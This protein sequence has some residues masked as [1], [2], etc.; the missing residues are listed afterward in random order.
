MILVFILIFIIFLSSL[1][2]IF[3]RYIN[4]LNIENDNL[5]E[6][7]SDSPLESDVAGSDLYAEKINAY[8][9]GNKSII[10]QSLFTNDTNILSQ[11]DSNDPAFSRCNII[12]SVSNGI[13]PSIFPRIMTENEMISQYNIGFNNFVGFLYY[14]HDVSTED[15]ELRAD[16]ALEI[17]KRKFKIDLIMVN[18]TEPNFF[19]F[20]GSCPEWKCYFNELTA[21][22][23]MDGYWKALDINRLT[24]QSYSQ[25]NHLSSSFI[26]LNSLDFFEGDFNITTD[27]VNFNLD[28]LDLT[29]L[30]S[31]GLESLLDQFDAILE[32]YGDL[33]NATI[34]EDELEQFIEIF[35]AF[36]LR[37]NSH[38]TS[39]SIQ[40]EGLPEGIVKIGKNQYE[41]DLWD[42]IG[43]YGDPLAPSEK[44]FIALTGA[45]LSNIEINILCTDIIDTTPM[46]FK[47]DDYLLEQLALL[48][49]YAGVDFD[50]ETLKEY[51]FDLFWVSEE[52]IKHSY[53][54][55][56]NKQDPS[57]V[58]NLLLQFGFQGFS[59][60]P[61]GIINPIQD[62]TI[63]YNISN[64][65]PNL[66]LKKELIGENASY[67]AFRNFSYYIS[68]ENVG[69]TTAWGV[70]TQLPL[71][72][73][74]FLTAI[75]S[76]ENLEDFKN[77]MWES[78][79][80]YY[81]NQYNSIEDFYNFDEDTRIFYFDT[82]GA[83][84]YDTF[85][86][87]FLNFTN[88]W[89]YNEN[90][91]III[92]DVY[93][94]YSEYFNPF[95]P[96][97]IVKELF[98]NEDSIRNDENW[99]LNP[100]EIISYQVD[101]VS[102]SNIDTFSP[103]YRNNISIEI[104][105]ETPEVVSGISLDGTTPEMALL[106]DNKSW[107]IGSVEKFLEQKI[108]INFIF[109][110]DTR[111]DFVNNT[112]EM[113]SIIINFSAPDSLDSLD[114]RIFNF[115]TE[116]FQDMNPYLDSVINNTWTFSFINR[117]NTLDWLFYPLDPENYTVLF[118]ILSINSA[119]FNISINDLDI[120]YSTRD[121][122]YNDD[123]GSRVAYSSLT[124]Y[125]QYERRSNSIPLSTYDGASIVATSYLTNYS[126]TPGDLN[127]Y[128][129]TFKN[130]G[131]DIAKNI[132]ISL[133]IPGMI[134][135]INNFTLQNSNLT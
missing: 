27:Q 69:N 22:F 92:D 24:S 96:I 124:S 53:I 47:F 85:Y 115:E 89:P 32:N 31:L 87:N 50:V 14:D 71:E 21:N 117:N 35:S 5:R 44:I 100:G 91:D 128:I 15:A 2:S 46:N 104:S 38:Y 70:P 77:V 19:P 114:F 20:I 59:F 102:L 54:K 90:S 109:K 80:R 97:S 65:E 93:N 110:N 42:A 18:S 119:E 88:L 37:N 51:S 127:A 58:I 7:E 132:S 30:E 101:N 1:N 116:E 41:F 83:G 62:L 86:P 78:I 123:S 48:F 118:K 130:I 103:F 16:R 3:E 57:D 81:P 134:D 113:V 25:N 76:E 66:I 63:T 52:G 68:A 55:P 122:N 10:K 95:I 108:E 131:S 4:I 26:L 9:A 126:S 79:Q 94:D 105:P 107:I 67:G 84:I 112:L 11:F 73:D 40:Y 12:F 29:F 8:V 23:P 75:S 72:L 43:Y 28:F 6:Y 39:I 64:S 98:M 121:I 60:I 36:T 56:V 135:K 17:I 129:I 13:N 49:Y 82:Y 45:I 133:L 120:E 33:F 125:V 106:N 74:D 111:I 61:T 34:S 99:R